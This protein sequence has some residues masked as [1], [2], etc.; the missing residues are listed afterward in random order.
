[1]I[2]M[3]IIKSSSYLCNKEIFPVSVSSFKKLFISSD[4]DTEEEE[5]IGTDDPESIYLDTL[6]ILIFSVCKI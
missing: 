6:K 4:R 3:S 2:K 5:N 1:M